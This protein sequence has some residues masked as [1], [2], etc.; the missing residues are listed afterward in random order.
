MVENLPRSVNLPGAIGCFH[1][2]DTPRRQK[3]SAAPRQRYAG[4]NSPPAS[5][6][7]PSPL[8]LTQIAAN[9]GLHGGWHPICTT[10]QLLNSSHQI[11][12]NHE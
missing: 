9:H 4:W 7:P 8:H 10:P 12:A 11:E 6:S 5:Y 1:S 2:V 3:N